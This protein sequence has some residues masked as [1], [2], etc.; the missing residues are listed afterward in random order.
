MRLLNVGKI[1]VGDWIEWSHDGGK[2]WYR[3]ETPVCYIGCLEWDPNGELFAWWEN[4][5]SAWPV[6]QCRK[7]KGP[8]ETT[9][10]RT[11]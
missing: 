6:E 4:R 10:R 2:T 3:A 11:C 5:L 9:E 8:D 1:K 7:V